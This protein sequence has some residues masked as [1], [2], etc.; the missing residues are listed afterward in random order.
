MEELE[1][2]DVSYKKVKSPWKKI[3]KTVLKSKKY[4]S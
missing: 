2:E 3:I 4:Q 1:L